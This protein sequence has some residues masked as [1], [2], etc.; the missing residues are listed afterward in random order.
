MGTNNGNVQV[1]ADG[2]GTWTNIT[3]QFYDAG[4]PKPG[5]KGDLNPYDR[6]VKRVVPSAFDENTAYVA[7]S[8]Y[9][10]HGEDRTWLF[11]TKDLGKTW[12]DI[13]GGMNNPIFDV[14]EDPDNAN[15]LYLGTDNGIWV[16]VD[17]GKTW[18]AFAA[19]RSRRWSSGTWQSRGA[20]ARWPSAPM[21]AASSWRTSRR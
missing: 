18:T 13:S 3:S 16:T 20:T 14:E 1:S 19:R 10:T 7:F 17:Q 6:W 21:R 5:I 8:G 4:K 11:V 2:G 12:A 15:V 9:R